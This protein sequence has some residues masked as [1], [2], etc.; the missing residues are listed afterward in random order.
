[1]Y[2]EYVIKEKGIDFSKTHNREPIL[3]WPRDGP[4]EA[5]G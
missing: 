4:I 5:V 2:C 1:M 3:N